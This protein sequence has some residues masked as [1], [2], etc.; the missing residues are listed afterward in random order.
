MARERW[1]SV[2]TNDDVHVNCWGVASALDKWNKSVGHRSNATDGQI[3][4]LGEK[5]DRLPIFQP[6][7]H[8]ELV[9]TV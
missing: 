9:N 3:E 1:K 4:V 8:N 7:I 2:L 6:Q 5:F